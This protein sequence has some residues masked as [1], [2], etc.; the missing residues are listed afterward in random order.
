MN[1]DND[2]DDEREQQ[3]LATY[4]DSLNSDYNC[5]GSVGNRNLTLTVSEEPESVGGLLATDLPGEE[6]G[7]YDEH[8]YP[9]D[10]PAE[11][12][13]SSLCPCCPIE[14]F[15]FEKRFIMPR[16]IWYHHRLIIT[17]Q[18]LQEIDLA[19]KMRSLPS[20]FSAN[21]EDD[22]CV[23]CLFRNAC[24]GRYAPYGT[25][26]VRSERDEPN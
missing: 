24:K 10:D 1:T 21:K 7:A 15:E 5:L 23:A 8:R 3:D 20:C 14:A 9:F 18:Q 17:P 4:E 19:I 22:L 13:L 16:R 12:I 6:A 2:D 26:R 25:I 11:H